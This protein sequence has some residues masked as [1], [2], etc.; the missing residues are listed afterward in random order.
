MLSFDNWKLCFIDHWIIADYKY[1]KQH[2]DF[3]QTVYGTIQLHTRIINANMEIQNGDNW[4]WLGLHTVASLYLQKTNTR[5]R[6]LFISIRKKRV[7]NVR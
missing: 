4:E 2:S 1:L 6:Q 7:V 3:I 5:N